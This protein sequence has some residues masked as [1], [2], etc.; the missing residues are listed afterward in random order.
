MLR[1]ENTEHKECDKN[2]RKGEGYFK[3]LVV[4]S[5][6]LLTLII[7]VLTNFLKK[8]KNG[9]PIGSY[10]RNSKTSLL[11]FITLYIFFYI[12]E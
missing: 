6:Y 3:W 1:Y 9:G 12:I 4:L 7:I 11:L 5:L 2:D 8:S 10:F